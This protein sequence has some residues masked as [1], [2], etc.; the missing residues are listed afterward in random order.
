MIIYPTNTT[1]ILIQI[2]IQKMSIIQMMIVTMMMMRGVSRILWSTT[3]KKVR[4]KTL[5]KN[6]GYIKKWKLT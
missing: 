3:K 5:K 2:L 4:K 1:L 6:R